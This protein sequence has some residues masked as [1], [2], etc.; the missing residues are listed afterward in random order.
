MR[1]ARNSILSFVLAGGIGKRLFPLTVE[2]TKPSVP[3]GGK[4]RII[5]FALSNL[6][7]SGLYS[8]YVLVQY[9][10][11]SLIEHVRTSWKKTGFLPEHFITIV[12]PQMRREEIQEAF[13]RGTADSIYQNINLIY[14][15][16]PRLVAVFAGD[17]IYRMDVRQMIDHHNKTKADLTIAVTPIDGRYATEFGIVKFNSAGRITEFQEKPQDCKIRN[18]FASM[19]NY[20]F[21]AGTLVETLEE[22]IETT[23]SHDFGHDIIPYLIKKKAKVQA[24]D[25]STNRIPGMKKYEAPYYWRDAGTIKSYWRANMDLLGERPAIDLANRAWPIYASSTDLPPSYTIDTVLDNTLVG[26][27]MRAHSAVVR[28]SILGRGVIIKKGA[29]I[30][31]SIIMDFTVIGENCRIK[32]AIIDRYNNISAG[33][34]I[35]VNKESD[36]KKYFLD[37]SGIVVV[38]RGERKKPWY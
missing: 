11:Q 7:N 38:K 6:V 32:K 17:H 16:N 13:Y 19:G 36:A 14:D 12:P 10:S 20:I 35:G 3:F 23:K 31:D 9:K 34:S 15:F 33:T 18:V 2:R 4:Y 24:Y 30:L 22:M 37:P 28:N 26:A 29:Q 27:G 21:N 5:D 1:I 25:F 8:I